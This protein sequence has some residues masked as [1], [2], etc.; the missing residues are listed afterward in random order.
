MTPGLVLLG[1]EWV[2]PLGLVGLVLPLVVLLAAR[3]PS[4][5]RELATGTIAIWRRVDPGSAVHARRARP[6]IPLVVWLIALALTAG[7]LALGGPQPRTSGSSR[8]WT[9][10]VDLSPSM[11][12]PVD[13]ADPQS[14]LRGEVAYQRAE[15]WMRETASSDDTF[16][17]VLIGRSAS[18]EMRGAPIPA[19]GEELRELLQRSG[20]EGLPGPFW[21]EHDRPGTL[22]I[23]DRIPSY[24]PQHAGYAVSGGAAVAGPVASSGT[25]RIDWDT[26]GWAE[27]EGGA[28][29]GVVR[30]TR[31]RTDDPA[32]GATRDRSPDDLGLP[33]VLVD[34]ITA[35]AE[36]RALVL[37][38]DELRGAEEERLVVSFAQASELQ[39]STL[40][41]DGWSVSGEIAAQ[42][43]TAPGTPLDVWR[44]SVERPLV[45]AHPG[46]LDVSWV[47]LEEPRGDPAA[48]A[49]SWAAL[50]DRAL[51]PAR[52]V[53]ALA[54][55]RAA[56]PSAFRPPSSA[57]LSEAQPVAPAYDAWLAA[58]A[59]LLAFAA[60]S[61]WSSGRAR[62]D[63]ST[64]R[65]STLTRGPA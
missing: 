43:S 52:G 18:G 36:A 24:E 58:A 46:R 3:T 65:P 5:P 54:E 53:V 20:A 48:F 40:S 12:L 22:W 41:R 49:V 10:I 6:R 11:S 32:D 50:L 56:G 61:V 63:A 45:R 42:Q 17:Q 31:S 34:V 2:R 26:E 27:V 13:P 30:L 44:D 25:T 51:L 28:A 7:G 9:L 59:A 33:L 14:L 1:I 21:H 37:R 39:A 64:A 60:L 15:Q 35:W 29:I 38:Q 62:L 47:S 57:P 19:T 23:T 8:T 55:R 4:R 16:E